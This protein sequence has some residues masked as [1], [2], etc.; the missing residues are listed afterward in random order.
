[1]TQDTKTKFI[2]WI[3]RFISILALALWIFIL[4]SISL[5]PV[6]FIEQAFYCMLGTMLTFG[7]I[8]LLYKGLER[9]ES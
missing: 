6:P 4:Y 8:R 2:I 3:K 1:M 9:L 7:C 5:S